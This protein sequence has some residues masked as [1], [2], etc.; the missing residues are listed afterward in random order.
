M[1][2]KDFPSNFLKGILKANSP[3]L[4]PL[5]DYKSTKE[6]KL[7]INNIELYKEWR[8]KAKWFYIVS[9]QYPYGYYS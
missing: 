2:D 6:Y 9:Q 1:D 5:I 3:L 7:L 4:I 8:C